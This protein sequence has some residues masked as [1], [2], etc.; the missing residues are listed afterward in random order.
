[1][2]ATQKELAHKHTLTATLFAIQIMD[3]C[4]VAQILKYANPNPPLLSC[5]PAGFC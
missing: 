3:L 5:L 4:S 2:T 1:M